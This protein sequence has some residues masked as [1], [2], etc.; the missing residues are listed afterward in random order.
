[1]VRNSYPDI[2]NYNSVGGREGI[3]A[4]YDSFLPY[5]ITYEFSIIDIDFPVCL[6]FGF[7]WKKYPWFFN[8]DIKC[9]ISNYDSGGYS[10]IKKIPISTSFLDFFLLFFGGLCFDSFILNILVNFMVFFLLY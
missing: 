9:D 3:I 4:H 6:K 10:I 8:Y 2:F 5:N 7:M 1:M